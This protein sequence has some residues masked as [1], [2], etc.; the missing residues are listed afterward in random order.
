MIRC[1]ILSVECNDLEELTIKLQIT[2]FELVGLSSIQQLRFEKKGKI[3]LIIEDC[4]KD[5][6]ITIPVEG[7]RD[8]WVI[9]VNRT[10]FT[11]Q[12]KL[13]ETF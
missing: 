5:M 9:T 1:F 8:L 2:T 12:F 11:L 4:K 13:R 6:V 3:N 10:E 7:G